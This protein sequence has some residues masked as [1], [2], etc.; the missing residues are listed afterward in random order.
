MS[1]QRLASPESSRPKQLELLPHFCVPF[2][3]SH[4]RWHPPSCIHAGE[5]PSAD[6]VHELLCPPE[7]AVL[8]QYRRDKALGRTTSSSADHSAANATGGS[9]RLSSGSVRL[10]PGLEDESL[11]S[12]VTGRSRG[13]PTQVGGESR[14]GGS[15]RMFRDM[16]V[17]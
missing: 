17:G 6:N 5:L 13:A 1:W 8:Q 4:L 11:P 3:H 16:G 15:S 2:F 10:A 7:D 12:A 14:M 9:Q